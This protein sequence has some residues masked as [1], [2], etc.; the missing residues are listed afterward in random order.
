MVGKKWENM[1]KEQ[2]FI[3]ESGIRLSKI[4]DTKHLTSMILYHTVF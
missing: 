4:T 2:A 1:T 3:F